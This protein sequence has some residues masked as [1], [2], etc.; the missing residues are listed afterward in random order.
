MT[1]NRLIGV[2]LLVLGILDHSTGLIQEILGDIGLP[3]YAYKLVQLVGIV[4]TAYVAQQDIP[5]KKL[6]LPAVRRVRKPKET[7]GV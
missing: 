6:K 4:L 2:V 7:A 1:Q 3:G 5:I